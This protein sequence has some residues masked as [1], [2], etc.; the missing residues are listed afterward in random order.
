MCEQQP[1]RGVQQ[2]HV[3]RRGVSP[4][5]SVERS[6]VVIGDDLA[7]VRAQVGDQRVADALCSAP[8]VGPPVSGVRVRGEEEPRGRGTDRRKGGVGVRE[9]PREQSIRLLGRERATAEDRSELQNAQTESER[10]QRMPR[11]AQQLRTGEVH[12]GVQVRAERPQDR[13][14]RA[15]IAAET[16]GGAVDVAPGDRRTTV[17]ERLR[18]RDLGRDPVD[19]V[20]E[21]E[22]AEERRAQG[23]RLN[24]RSHVV[25]ESRKG[26]LGG[27]HSAARR[28]GGFEH[29][30]RVPGASESDGGREAVRPAAHDRRVLGHGVSRPTVRGRAGRH[31]ARRARP[32]R[33][34][35][36][37]PASRRVVTAIR[38]ARPW[39]RSGSPTA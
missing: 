21:P 4:V 14:P 17:L 1:G 31:P 29:T 19:A 11:H 16:V 20:A 8:R 30:Y 28:R 33:C 36:T 22:G 34:R 15:R 27:A 9:H 10:G 32:R 7:A 38:R 26:Q 13:E 24:G 39:G 23:R 35:P 18:I 2:E 5:E 3:A 25:A 12:D 37:A 6:D